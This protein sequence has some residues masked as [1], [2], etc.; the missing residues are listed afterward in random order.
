MK[1]SM[2]TKARSFDVG[3]TVITLRAFDAVHPEDLLAALARHARCDWGEAPQ[4]AQEYVARNEMGVRNGGRV[5]SMYQ[6]RS[7]TEFWIFTRG[8]CTTIGLDGEI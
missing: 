7:G 1:D 2:E 4:V 5:Y 6:D 8:G 3:Q